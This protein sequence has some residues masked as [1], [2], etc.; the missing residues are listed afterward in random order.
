LP[1]AR[2]GHCGAD[3]DEGSWRTLLILRRVTTDEVRTLVT[4]WPG[5]ASIEVRG[6]ARCHG[7]IARKRS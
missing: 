2:C 7:A 6:C 1:F 3:Y 4:V 5:G